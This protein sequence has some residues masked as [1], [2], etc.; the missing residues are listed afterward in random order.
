MTR[1]VKKA[2]TLSNYCKFYA[3]ALGGHLT[4]IP[5]VSFGSICTT[6]DVHFVLQ[7]VYIVSKNAHLA[8]ISC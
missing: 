1:P 6:L 4:M 3:F 5:I 7:I 8:T 2:S